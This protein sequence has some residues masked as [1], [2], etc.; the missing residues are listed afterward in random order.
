[1]RNYNDVEFEV[2]VVFVSSVVTC[3]LIFVG[4]A[5]YSFGENAVLNL[6]QNEK[7]IYVKN[8]EYRCKKVSE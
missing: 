3:M 4:C 5:L 2:F 6:C 8:T 7:A 1:M